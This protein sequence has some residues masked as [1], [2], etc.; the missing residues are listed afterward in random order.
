MYLVKTQVG[1]PELKAWKYPLAGD[2]VVTTI[3]RV[4]IDVGSAKVIRLK[5]PPDQH[6][7]SL[8]DDVACRGSEWADVEWSP[9]SKHL[10]FVSTS[11][12]HRAEQLRIAD[13]DTGKVHDILQE[14]V[15]TFFESGNGAI[16][17]RYLP[18][19]SE[20]IWFSERENWGHIYVYDLHTG[21][22]KNRITSGD[23]NVTQ[24]LR[25]DE[26]NRMIYFLGVGREKG[27]DPY[28]VHL[29]RAGLDGNN[30]T[31]LT[32]ENATHSIS[33]SPSGRFLTDTYSR[34]DAAAITILRD[35]EGRLVAE[36][37]KSDLSLLEQS[38]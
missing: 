12:D 28:F 26:K 4:V 23:W 29:Y 6:R 9:D 27:E 25:V 11:R 33:L 32:P 14:T 19:S 21:R 37:G 10:A 5:V 16:N 7:S 8:C 36:V 24:V 38:G 30:L 18:G 34:P 13:A 1:H 15:S 20:V 17:W 3:Q 35:S 22:M 31:L 2:A